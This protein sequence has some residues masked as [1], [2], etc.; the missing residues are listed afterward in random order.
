MISYNND[1]C[2]FGTF[3]SVFLCSLQTTLWVTVLGSIFLVP[4]NYIGGNGA[5]GLDRLSV[6]NIREQSSILWVHAASIYIFSGIFMASLWRFCRKVRW[7]M[8]LHGV[9]EIVPKKK[10][11]QC[12]CLLPLFIFLYQYVL[13]RQRF[14]L[15]PYPQT[16]SLLVRDI[17]ER[18]T[19][20]EVCIFPGPSL[21]CRVPNTNNVWDIC[22]IFLQLLVFFNTTIPGQVL[23]LHLVEDNRSYRK[24]KKKKDAVILKVRLVGSR[25]VRTILWEVCSLPCNIE[26]RYKTHDAIIINVCKLIY[27][28]SGFNIHGTRLGNVHLKWSSVQG[29]RLMPLTIMKAYWTSTIENY[30]LCRYL[31]KT[32]VWRIT[33]I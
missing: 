3:F 21:F 25:H 32:F 6:S 22:I 33:L 24:V 11:F 14:L 23:Q 15:G 17:P 13:V 1:S 27:S 7:E 4:V 8:Y 16:C 18:M 29:K 28:W 31:P 19:K 12:K 26:E 10:N 30:Q 5:K 9:K 20:D 2:Y